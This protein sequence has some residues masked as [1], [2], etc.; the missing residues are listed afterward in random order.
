MMHFVSISLLAIAYSA[1]VCVSLALA[2]L[3]CVA[4]PR[5]ILTPNGIDEH[6]LDYFAKDQVVRRMIESLPEQVN[7]LVC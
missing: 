5:A 3:H 1:Q 4:M 7:I 2:R 6:V